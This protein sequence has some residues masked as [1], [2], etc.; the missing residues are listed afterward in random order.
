MF[1]G[2][3]IEAV[4]SILE[5]FFDE[6]ENEVKR[7]ELIKAKVAENKWVKTYARFSENMLQEQL[8]ALQSQLPGM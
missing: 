7:N 4:E 8:R 2:K 1:V 6:P 5:C 3:K